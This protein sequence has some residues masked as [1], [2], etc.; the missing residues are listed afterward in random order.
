MK[1][2]HVYASQCA[3]FCPDLIQT[4]MY[5]A[6]PQTAEEGK[7]RQ[8]NNLIR[9]HLSSRVTTL[10]TWYA[11]IPPTV[12]ARV[13]PQAHLPTFGMLFTYIHP[14]F[15]YLIKYQA[16][17]QEMFRRNLQFHCYYVRAFLFMKNELR[18]SKGKAML[19]RKPVEGEI[20]CTWYIRLRSTRHTNPTHRKPDTY[21]SEAKAPRLE[22]Q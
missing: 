9:H 7:T 2:T 10:R 6:I 18:I 11:N 16:C 17:T 13:L 12:Q 21:T 8:Q 1:K 3:C 15:Q 5:N 20:P 22:T 19:N 14:Y 4:K